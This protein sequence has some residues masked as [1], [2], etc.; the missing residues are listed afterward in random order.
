MMLK[1]CCGF[2]LKTGTIILGV[3]H[4]VSANFPSTLLTV[5][6]TQIKKLQFTRVAKLLAISNKITFEQS[7]A[8]LAHC[9]KKSAKENMNIKKTT[10]NFVYIRVDVNK[11]SVLAT[12]FK[13]SC[14]TCHKR[15]SKGE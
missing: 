9:L 13:Y 11:I 12:G 6:N 8:I 10:Y 15:V 4:I 3:L 2:S 7:T 5:C 14:S 1:Q